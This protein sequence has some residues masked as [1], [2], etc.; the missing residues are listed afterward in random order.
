MTCAAPPY[1]PPFPPPAFPPPHTH[2]PVTL[3]PH[4]GGPPPFR[5]HPPLLS[6]SP[7]SISQP[8][9]C[10]A[11]LHTPPPCTSPSPPLSL[12]PPP[13]PYLSPFRPRAKEMEGD[14]PG[15]SREWLGGRGW[16]VLSVSYPLSR[17]GSPNPGLGG[18]EDGA[19]GR[20]SAAGGREGEA[21]LSAPPS[22]AQYTLPRPLPR[23]PPRCSAHVGPRRGGWRNGKKGWYPPSC[24]AA[25]PGCTRPQEMAHRNWLQQRPGTLLGAFRP[26][27]SRACSAPLPPAPSLH[28]S[29]ALSLHHSITPPS[30]LWA[31]EDP[32]SS[33][34]IEA[35]C[36]A[37]FPLRSTP[38]PL[39]ISLPH[40]P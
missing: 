3:A 28:R 36:Q 5:S 1:L 26:A 29:I 37:V 38:A 13:F 2:P 35:T 6:K 7:C 15:A 11:F 20:A 21:A 34:L 22:H 16:P 39:H 12:T 18:T 8:Q 14:P 23:T 31:P 25:L 9:D 19:W 27:A 17:S 10:V 30:L 4:L 33:F 32:A 24:P 40:T